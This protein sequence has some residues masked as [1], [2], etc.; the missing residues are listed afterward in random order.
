MMEVFQHMSS[1]KN[2]NTV[3]FVY[4]FVFC[5]SSLMMGCA[6]SGGSSGS[7]SGGSSSNGDLSSSP[8]NPTTGTADWSKVQQDVN[9]N[10]DGGTYNGQQLVRLDV[11]RQA[12]V[13]T[14]P[15]PPTFTIVMPDNSMAISSNL[16]GITIETSFNGDQENWSVV[17]PLRYVLR[18]ANVSSALTLPNGNALP[19]LPSGEINGL[20]LSFPQKPDFKVHLYFTINA[21]AAFV[22]TPNWQTNWGVG[23]YVKNQT[24][25]RII[26]YMSIVPN[27]GT[28]S[29]GVYVAARLPDDVARA[30]AQLTGL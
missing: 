29:S 6:K 13:L 17:V 4:L 12:L 14:L 7:S 22:E 16:P 3:F 27:K 9:S 8:S 15:L 30:L 5:L 25:T 1:R 21:V 24:K 20:T 23:V 11:A 2:I 18:G 19:F 26:G 10:A 28:F